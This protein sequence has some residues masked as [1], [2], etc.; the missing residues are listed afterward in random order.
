MCIISP[1]TLLTSLPHH[2]LAPRHDEVCADESAGVSSSRR[3][4]LTIDLTK[5]GRDIL[6]ARAH[7]CGW[8]SGVKGPYCQKDVSSTGPNSRGLVEGVTTKSD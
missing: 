5:A 7:G 8:S 2:G 3:T 6:M 1:H 4:E